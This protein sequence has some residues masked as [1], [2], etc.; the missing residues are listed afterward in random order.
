MMWVCEPVVRV[1]DKKEEGIWIRSVCKMWARRIQ[2][3]RSVI[4]C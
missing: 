3:W 1:E 4:R 2:K